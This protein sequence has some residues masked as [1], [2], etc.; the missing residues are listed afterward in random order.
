MNVFWGVK[1][2]SRNKRHFMVEAGAPQDLG[3]KKGQG[4][5]PVGCEP[6]LGPGGGRPLRVVEEVG[7]LSSSFLLLGG[8]ARAYLA[9]AARHQV[10]LENKQVEGLGAY[11]GPARLV[12]GAVALGAGRRHELEV[13]RL[14]RAGDQGF[15]VAL[16]PILNVQAGGK[17]AGL[18]PGCPGSP[19][20]IAPFRRVMRN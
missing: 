2:N 16:Q 17:I 6:W 3:P 18:I 9:G 7:G 14:M 13:A 15:R 1:Y 11:H 20:F 12:G 19:H 4:P 5:R 8:Q 10:H